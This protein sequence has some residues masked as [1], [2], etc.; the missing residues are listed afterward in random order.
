[1]AD[2]YDL[3]ANYS[4]RDVEG[5]GANVFNLDFNG[6]SYSADDILYIGKTP[7][8]TL[9]TNIR[10]L[11]H[12]GGDGV[13]DIGYLNVVNELQYISIAAGITPLTTDTQM[14]VPMTPA[15]NVLIDGTTDE[16]DGYVTS[17]W[18]PINL[19]LEVKTPPTGGK[20]SVVVEYS[21]Y[22]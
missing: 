17:V 6:T 11:I 19:M 13:F 15:G 9:V 7:S 1:M 14:R 10:V 2:Y 16:T 5:V 3:S 8:G 21:F 18:G 4:R 20:I 12:E 22:K